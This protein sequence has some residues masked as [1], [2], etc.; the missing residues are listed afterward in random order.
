[1]A[2][3]D[4]LRDAG[5]DSGELERASA[6]LVECFRAG[7][8]VLIFGN[9]GS[10]A[11]A[12]HMATELV[13]RFLLEKRRALPAIALTTDTSALTA[14]ANDFGFERVFARQVEALGSRGD[15][16]IAISTS[17]ASPN[18]LEGVRA[19]QARGLRTIGLA[20]PGPSALEELVELPVAVRGAEGPAIQEAQLMVEHA[21]CAAVEE[22]LFADGAAADPPEPARKVVDWD[23]LLELRESWRSERL[24][25]VWTNGVFDLLHVGHVRSLEAARALGSVLVVGVNAD[26]TVSAAKGPGRPIVP[27]EQ[28]AE[29][30]AA[31]ESVDYVVVFDEPTPERALDRLRPEIHAKGAD[32]R[33]KPIPER[34][35]VEGYGGRVEL[36]PL[37]E[38]VSTTELSERAQ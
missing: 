19:A 26:A 32:Y 30:V 17:G 16:A 9:G 21:L 31:L 3:R 8:K 10:A 27:A 28:R 15:V 14:I 35:V 36:L 6:A 12:Q 33:D 25:V 2:D 5:V 20:G 37:V 34:A 4:R 13:G 11:D 23:E 29:V 7:G 1:M 24:T 18:V 22:G 38:G